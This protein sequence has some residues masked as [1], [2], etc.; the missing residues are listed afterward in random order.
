MKSLDRCILHACRLHTLSVQSR[1]FASTSELRKNIKCD[2]LVVGGG[3]GGCAM[4]AK[5]AS[6]LGKN[7]VVIVEPKDVHY[8]Q[9]MFTLIGGGMKTLADSARSMASV[10][11]SK[12][13]WVKDEVAQF[14]PKLN[15]VTTKNGDTI[16]YNFMLVAVGLQ[17]NYDKV[18]GLEDA[19]AKDPRVCSN[20]SPQYVDKTFKALQNFQGGPAIFTFPNTPVKCAGAPQKVMY[21]TEEF[22]RKVGKR[23][24]SDIKYCTSLGVIFGVKKYAAA[25]LEL[26]KKRGIEVNLRQN[27]I[28]V[29]H[30]TSEAVF[31]YLDKPGE[32]ITLKYSLLHAT[33]PMSAPDVLSKCSDLTDKA[34]Y[35]DV[36][37]TNLQHVK[38]PN[39]FGIGDCTNVPTSKTAAA[40]AGQCGVIKKHLAA[41]MAGKPLPSAEYDGYTSCPLVTGYSSCILAEFDYDGQPLETFPFNQGKERWSTFFMKKAIMPDL[42][43]H[44][45]LN[46]YWEGPKIFRKILHFGM[47]K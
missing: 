27:L 7:K 3:A 30:E 43:W 46:G 28:K 47:G 31:E 13:Q 17:L 8:Y 45:M 21:I 42:Y 11:P 23:D 22:L 35:L 34:G 14:S 39:V 10:L 37:K 25:L 16:E 12:A 26:C 32:T 40:V 44:G 5:F 18:K 33:P 4:A 6:K 9:P 20:F 19:L 24:V 29:K 1:S 41:V 15:S 2:L 38:F 36:N